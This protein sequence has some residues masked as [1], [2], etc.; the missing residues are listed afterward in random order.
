MRTSSTWGLLIATGTSLGL[1]I[2]LSRLA[3]DRGVAPLTFV[4]IPALVAGL[5][6]AAVAALRHGRPAGGRALVG[7]GLV[8]GL[9]GN[10]LPNTL[11]AW[12]SGRAGASIAALAFTLPPIFTLGLT[13]LLGH[14]R[15]RWQRLSAVGLG[16]SGAVWLAASRVAGGQLSWS[17]AAALL[18]IPA[19]VAV[20]NVFRAR[21]LPPSVPAEWLG[22]AMM[23]GAFLTLLPAWALGSEPG[24]AWTGAGAPYLAAQVANAALAAVLF[25]QLQR[26]ADPVT[27]SFIGYVIA[28]TGALLGALLLGE[29]LPWQLAPA[30]GLILGG[31]AIIQATP[32]HARDPRPPTDRDS[33]NGELIPHSR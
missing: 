26:R 20:G 29:R 28:L 33:A 23:L 18:A 30:A 25:F 8:A 32:P 11:I 19:S 3:V 31:F 10:A 12:L 21:F 15:A 17:G 4:L 5:L 14:E 24:S 9:L 22:A 13:L 2:P 16:L 27:M 1:A 7:F 6:L